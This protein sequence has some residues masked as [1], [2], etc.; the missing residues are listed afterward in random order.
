MHLLLQK[1]SKTRPSPLTPFVH[2]VMKTHARIYP[3]TIQS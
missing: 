1:L 3:T 2:Y